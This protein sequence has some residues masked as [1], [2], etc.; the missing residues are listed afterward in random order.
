MGDVAKYRRHI[1]NSYTDLESSGREQRVRRGSAIDTIS[2]PERFA[3]E[4]I[5][6]FIVTDIGLPNS[7]KRNGLR[8]SYSRPV[9][10][11]LRVFGFI[12]RARRMARRRSGERTRAFT[13]RGV[14]GPMSVRVRVICS[15]AIARADRGLFLRPKTGEEPEA[16]P[17]TATSFVVCSARF[18]FRVAS[19]VRLRKR[20]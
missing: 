14:V 20:R 11:R 7:F 16:S 5:E 2:S 9:L 10:L 12:S 17:A 18:P 8:L 15:R 19:R 3:S 6:L 13:S 1:V 4:E